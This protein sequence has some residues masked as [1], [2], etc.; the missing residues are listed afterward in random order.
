MGS[1]AAAT[2][3]VPGEGKEAPAEAGQGGSRPTRGNDPLGAQGS[4]SLGK[5]SIPGTFFLYIFVGM[6]GGRAD[7]RCLR[8]LFIFNPVESFGGFFF[9][10][11][12][13]KIKKMV[14]AFDVYAAYL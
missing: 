1:H 11:L 3:R 9:W 14:L 6:G 5:Q 7:G 4:S 2:A 10:F 8:K 12:A 13:F